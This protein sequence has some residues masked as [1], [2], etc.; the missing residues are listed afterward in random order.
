MVL[1]AKLIIV[2]I[3]TP[4]DRVRVSKISAGMI[5]TIKLAHIQHHTSQHRLTRQRPIRRREAKV[6][7]PSNNNESPGRRIVVTFSGRELGEQNRGDDER[8]TIPEIASN[9]R[10]SAS[11][12]V[13]EEDTAELSHD[14]DDRA[15]ALVLEGVRPGDSDLGEDVG[16]VVLDGGDT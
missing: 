4:I 15:D 14:G 11:G 6:I 7:N 1:N 5:P 2:A 9:H 16:G 10:P 13:D 12:V 8:D 3:E